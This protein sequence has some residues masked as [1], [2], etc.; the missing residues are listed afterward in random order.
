MQFPANRIQY[1][2]LVKRVAHE[3][4]KRCLAG[5]HTTHS[6]WIKN[7][8]SQH[9]ITPAQPVTLVKSAE[10]EQQQTATPKNT[11]LSP[12]STTKNV[13]TSPQKTASPSVK[14]PAITQTSPMVSPTS[15][16]LE[17]NASPLPKKQES[18]KKFSPQQ[19][20]PRLLKP[21]VSIAQK[22]AKE[23]KIILEDYNNPN[24]FKGE[25]KK[26]GLI[27]S[28]HLNDDA[29]ISSLDRNNELNRSN[30]SSPSSIVEHSMYDEEY[31][32][33]LQSPKQISPIRKSRVVKQQDNQKQFEQLLEIQK[34][35]QNVLQQTIDEQNK[36]H[37][38]LKK[39]IKKLIKEKQA[40]PITTASPQEPLSSRML[41]Q[42]RQEQVQPSGPSTIKVPLISAMEK[43]S[44]VL[45][46]QLLRD[47]VTEELAKQDGR[48]L[49]QNIQ[50]TQTMLNNKNDLDKLLQ[51]LNQMEEQNDE[52]TRRHHEEK[53]KIERLQK[54]ASSSS[55]PL[56]PRSENEN[57]LENNAL[58]EFSNIENKLNLAFFTKMSP[59]QLHEITTYRKQF[60]KFARQIAEGSEIAPE[61]LVEMLSDQLLEQLLLEMVGELQQVTD[62]IYD[63]VTESEFKL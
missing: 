61:A 54:R 33:Y 5:I 22:Q 13:A 29:S 59:K 57:E 11:K 6:D 15:K 60:H 37:K 21:T 16:R 46:D 63:Q 31:E 42:F 55:V 10:K 19:I 32:D 35:Q 18:T 38:R 7:V 41:P 45:L 26:R 40:A 47:T 9:N 36:K 34:Q 12:K 1:L 27:T 39:K 52:I 58:E 30:H 24:N 25:R 2:N 62:E 53:R 14:K 48:E 20:S 44:E 4:V 43:G 23:E 8:M 50:L 17:H 49:E 51:L 56:I 28:L 3:D